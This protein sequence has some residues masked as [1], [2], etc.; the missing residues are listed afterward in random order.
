M[1]INIFAYIERVRDPK[2]GEKT[3]QNRK[4]RKR[5]KKDII[6]KD[7]RILLKNVIVKWLSRIRH[8]KMLQ[9][10]LFSGQ[11]KIAYEES[12][13]KICYFMAIVLE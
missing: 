5:G 12:G 10:M 6:S 2:A 13:G 11:R 7:H 8:E 9:K 3:K 1:C 4:V